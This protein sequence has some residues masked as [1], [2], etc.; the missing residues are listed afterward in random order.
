M[1][2]VG[3]SGE[4]QAGGMMWPNADQDVSLSA[5]GP[6]GYMDPGRGAG[7]H[8]DFMHANAAARHNAYR[9]S[10]SMGY[11]EPQQQSV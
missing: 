9:P 6:E 8:V 2:G 1:V 4:M 7:Q 10:K 11:P 5:P 3:Q